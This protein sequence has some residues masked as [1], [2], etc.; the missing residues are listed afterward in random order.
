VILFQAY[1]AL[2][3]HPYYFSYYNPLVGGSTKAPQVMM[4]GWGEGLDQAARYLNTKPDF[5]KLRVASWYSDG[6]FSYFFEG[7]TIQQDFP[8]DPAE[9]VKADYIVLY[10]HQWQRQLPSQE[11]LNFFEAMTPEKVIDIDGLEYARIYPMY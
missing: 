1:S 7:T 5:D 4:I 2:R 9:M 10:I 6:P 3:T 11:F 8:A